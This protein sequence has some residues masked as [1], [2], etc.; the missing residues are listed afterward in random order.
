MLPTVFPASS[1]LRRDQGDRGILGRVGSCIKVATCSTIV[2][3]RDTRTNTCSPELSISCSNA[4]SLWA[5]SSMIPLSESTISPTHS[6]LRSS[7]TSC[8]SEILSRHMVPSP[9]AWKETPK[10]PSELRFSVT[11]IGVARLS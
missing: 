6:R 10:R 8:A 5:S 4:S 7:S 1:C 2:L 9:G 3:W 11:S